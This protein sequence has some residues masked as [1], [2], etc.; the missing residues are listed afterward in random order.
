MLHLLI[1]QSDPSGSTKVDFDTDWKHI[2]YFILVLNSNL[3]PI[4]LCFRD[5]R[6]FVCQKPL[7][8]I[9]RPYIGHTGSQ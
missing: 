7:Y 3:G 5:I 6:A 4:L 8:S 9:P 1:V 2:W